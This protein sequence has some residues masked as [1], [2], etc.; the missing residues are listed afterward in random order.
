MF[1]KFGVSNSMAH[2]YFYVHNIIM[3]DI[4]TMESEICNPI[5]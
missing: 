4:K 3:N 5:L 1:I 2:F